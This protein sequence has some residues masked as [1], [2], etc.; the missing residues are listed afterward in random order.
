MEKSIIKYLEENSKYFMSFIS[1]ELYNVT[2]TYGY[3]DS[4]EY[5][6]KDPATFF[7]SQ[8]F[9]DEVKEMYLM[10]LE[11]KKEN[12]K[13]LFEEYFID[14]LDNIGFFGSQKLAD[15]IVDGVL[16]NNYGMKFN[17]FNAY[18]NIKN[19]LKEENI[20]KNISFESFKQEFKD[21]LGAFIEK[22]DKSKIFDLCKNIEVDIVLSPIEKPDFSD[23]A[24][25]EILNEVIIP[26]EENI[27]VLD[28]LGIN[29]TEINSFYKKLNKNISLNPITD[30]SQFEFKN[31]KNSTLLNYQDIYESA[32]EGYDYPVIIINKKLKEL[33]NIEN[34]NIS[35]NGVFSLIGKK[36]IKPLSE[37][38]F[39]NLKLRDVQ[40]EYMN[41]GR[42]EIENKDLNKISHS[43]KKIDFKKYIKP[44]G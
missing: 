24:T 10:S 17:I 30:L 16:F 41:F 11:N 9:K 34:E 42:K 31:N 21:C 39:E 38:N 3:F 13:K 6:D 7:N 36:G 29:N 1:G 23:M 44:R 35:G 25:F 33:T 5:R 20:E 26:T 2:S 28:R 19:D 8:E 37:V 27:E 12:T 43:Y 18:I 40:F 22:N 32:I 14:Y 15:N 4:K